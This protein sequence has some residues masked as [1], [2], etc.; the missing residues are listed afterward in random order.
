MTPQKKAN[1]AAKCSCGAAKADDTKI[2][3]NVDNG[4]ILYRAVLFTSLGD[5]QSGIDMA[6]GKQYLD[7]SQFADFIGG[8]FSCFADSR[9][10]DMRPEEALKGILN[11]KRKGIIKFSWDDALV[12]GED[13]KLIAKYV[14]YSP[15]NNENKCSRIS[16]HAHCAIHYRDGNNKFSNTTEKE[17]L[18]YYLRAVGFSCYP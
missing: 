8:S 11:E 2:A 1:K 7:P 15:P 3:P 12:K 13:Y 4:E 9:L 16:N 5:L 18:I 10:G 17:H 14:Y 6:S